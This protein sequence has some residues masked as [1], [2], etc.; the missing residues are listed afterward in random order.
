VEEKMRLLKELQWLDTEA[1]KVRA[2]L[3]KLQ[4]LQSGVDQE[5]DRLQVMADSLT[6]EMET[7]KDDLAQLGRNLEQEQENI[8]RSEKRLPEIKT[9]KEYLAVLK[10]IDTAKKLT[11]EY[12]DAS[13][14]KESQMES[15]RS[16][17]NEKTELL[18]EARAKAAQVR[19]E[20][21]GRI[22]ET[23]KQLKEKELERDGLFSALPAQ[24]AKRYKLLHDRRGGLAVV[25][26]RNGACY[27]CH[28]HL[29]PQ[30][31]NNLLRL[32]QVESCPHCN[33]LLY[34]EDRG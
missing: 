29:P 31:Y 20:V 6:Q 25:E 13:L 3:K 21:E 12:E 4:D 18:A 34:V 16:E 5:A 19:A 26:A 22:A 14:A 15:I 33:R 32:E 24:L 8:I 30:V 1:G 27:G 11:K 9:Q 23:S 7:L 10:E 17:S 28:M 2:E